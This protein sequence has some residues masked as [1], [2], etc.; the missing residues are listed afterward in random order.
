MQIEAGPYSQSRY[1]V[2]PQSLMS[3]SDSIITVPLFDVPTTWPPPGQQV[4]IVGFLQLFV[5][6]AGP[7]G[8][9]D[10]NATILN[11][12]GC[13]SATTAGPAVS[14]GGVSAIPVRLIHN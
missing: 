11:V 4:T 1:G 9:N 8:A 13:G 12:I 2:A 14:G 3:T 6:S 5:T 10:M 7:P